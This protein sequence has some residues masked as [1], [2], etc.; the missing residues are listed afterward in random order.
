MLAIQIM[1]S[2]VLVFLHAVGIWG[3]RTLTGVL[4]LVSSLVIDLVWLWSI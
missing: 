3:S 4:L 2:I 1:L